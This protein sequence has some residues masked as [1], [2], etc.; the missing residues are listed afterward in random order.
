MD[1]DIYPTPAAYEYSL[2]RKNLLYA[3]LVELNYG[4]KHNCSH[5][6]KKKQWGG[7]TAEYL[8]LASGMYILDRETAF[9]LWDWINK[10]YPI[11][12]Q[13]WWDV[14]YEKQ[15][16]LSPEHPYDYGSEEAIMEEWLNKTLPQFT[17]LT[18]DIHSV[19]PEYNPKFL[20]YHGRRKAEYPL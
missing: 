3:P 7:H 18:D 17:Q 2:P 12:S 15:L 9:S 10:D 5:M 20:H 4:E 8:A 13:K 11:N 1:L 19:H 14:Y 6:T 16:A